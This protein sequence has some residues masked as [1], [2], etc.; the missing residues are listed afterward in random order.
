MHLNTKYDDL[1]DEQNKGK[2]AGLESTLSKGKEPNVGTGPALFINDGGI[3]GEEKQPKEQT[4]TLTET[5][6]TPGVPD[7]E[8]N[9]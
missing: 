8:E 1:N 9:R 3:E 6:G 2:K 4:G 5:G 7:T